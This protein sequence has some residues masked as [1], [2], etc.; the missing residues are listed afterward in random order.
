MEPWKGTCPYCDVDTDHV[1]NHIRLSAAEHGPKHSYPDDWD[2]DARERIQ[3]TVREPTEGNEPTSSSGSQVEP[4]PSDGGDLSESPPQTG[5]DVES[6]GAGTTVGPDDGEHSGPTGG[7]HGAATELEFSDAPGDAR[8][9]TCG[10]CDS[11]VSY[12][13]A[14]DNGHE[15][16]WQGVT[17]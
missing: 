16:A 15:L 3:N 11:P 5:G 9:Y 1:N 4:T 8:E 2:K 12:L 6:D 13:E 14:C 7:S 10:E 17:A